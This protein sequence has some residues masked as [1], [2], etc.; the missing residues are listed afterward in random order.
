MSF[1]RRTGSVLALLLTAAVVL[2]VGSAAGSPMP[3]PPAGALP[4]PLADYQGQDECSATAKPGVLA[5]KEL[6]LARYPG[7][8]NLGIVR[9]CHLGARSEHKEGRAFDWGVRVDRPKE[10]GYARDLTGWLLATDASGVRYANARRLG[11]MYMIWN[12][13]IWSASRAAEGWRTYSGPNPHTDHVHF[14]FTW[15]AAFKLTSYWTGKTYGAGSAGGAL[16]ARY[17]T[18][19]WTAYSTSRSVRLVTSLPRG[20]GRL[21]SV[22]QS[23]VGPELVFAGVS[24]AGRPASAFGGTY[25]VRVPLPEAAVVTAAT[26]TADGGVVV[27]GTVPAPVA[28][29]ETDPPAPADPPTRDLLLVRVTPSGGLD[30]S[31]GTDG[32]AVF[33]LGGDDSVAAIRVTAGDTLLVTG[34]T[35]FDGVANLAAA[36]TL[37]SGALDTTFGTGGITTSTARGV[38]AGTAILPLPSGQLLIGCRTATAGCLTRLTTH[39]QLDVGFGTEGV[40]LQPALTSVATLIAAPNAKWLAAGP[41]TDGGATVLRLRDTGARDPL[42]GTGGVSSARVSGCTV[43]PTGLVVRWDGSPVMSG[44]LTGCTRGGFVSRFMPDGQLDPRWS[45]NGVALVGRATTAPGALVLQPDGRIVLPATIG[46]APSTD[47]TGVR[48]TV[49]G[50]VQA[51]LGTIRSA[52]ITVYGTPVT[53]T[54]VVRST[55]DYKGAPGV[56]VQFYARRFGTTTWIKIGTSTTDSTG[57]ARLRHSPVAGTTYRTRS[58]TTE[59]LFSA[60][61]ATVVVRVR[62][63]LTARSTTPLVRRGTPVVLSITARPGPPGRPILL[64]RMIDGRWTTVRRPTL[65]STGTARVRAIS[66]KAVSRSYRWVLPPDTDHLTGYSRTVRVEWR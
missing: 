63:L 50:P 14:S 2:P 47:M 49:V 58:T 52:P 9:A 8:R 57:K 64:Q 46:T 45:T 13:R 36:R 48:F 1:R 61:S 38:A 26:A 17:G 5:F 7:S 51:R 3:P 27:A 6:L 15:P 37:P 56:P 31:F 33:D 25:R 4:E 43:R 66:T 39:G 35:V 20:D 10:A 55:A 54:G 41:G 42:F 11:I 22:G 29:P 40:V 30:A 18:D 28:P 16:D 53:V 23:S 24:P 60:T 19:S 34:N 12:R 65:S 32:A 59:R 21:L 62:P 44:R